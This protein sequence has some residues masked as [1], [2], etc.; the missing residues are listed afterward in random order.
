MWENLHGWRRRLGAKIDPP[1]VPK[2]S[3]Y[4]PF[5]SLETSTLPFVFLYLRPGCNFAP[6]RRVLSCSSRNGCLTLPYEVDSHTYREPVGAP[7]SWGDWRSSGCCR[8]ARGAVQLRRGVCRNWA[9]GGLPV[10]YLRRFAR[11]AAPV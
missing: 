11:S 5:F 6:E 7:F 8:L 10:K 9:C 2:P 1:T 3:N 4:R